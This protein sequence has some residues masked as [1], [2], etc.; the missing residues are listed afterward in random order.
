MA[1]RQEAR[2]GAGSQPA[3]QARKGYRDIGKLAKTELAEVDAW[4]AK[5]R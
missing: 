2:A 3:E 4:L 1:S 5:N